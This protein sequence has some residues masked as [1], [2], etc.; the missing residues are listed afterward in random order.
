MATAA[1]FC[2]ALALMAGRD[3]DA[4][5]HEATAWVHGKFALLSTRSDM[6]GRMPRSW[7]PTTTAVGMMT[8]TSATKA[9]REQ[10]VAG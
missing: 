5:H 1:L 10:N 6:A 2:A 9:R 7:N 8:M 4:F 3:V